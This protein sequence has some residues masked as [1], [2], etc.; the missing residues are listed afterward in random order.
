MPKEEVAAKDPK[1]GSMKYSQEPYAESYR[2]T[3]DNQVIKIRG[4]R[5]YAKSTLSQTLVS[6]STKTQRRIVK[7]AQG[8][9]CN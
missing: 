2:D 7:V 4:D 5:G 9:N 3:T 1:A 6:I 8:Y